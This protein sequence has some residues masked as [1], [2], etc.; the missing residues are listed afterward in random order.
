ML[1]LLSHDL[2]TY[3]MNIVIRT[4]QLKI[5]KIEKALISQSL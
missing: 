1:R 2:K 4:I 5:A 3:F